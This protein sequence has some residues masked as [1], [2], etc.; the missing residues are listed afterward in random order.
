MSKIPT[1]ITFFERLIP[2]ILAGKKVITIRDQSESYYQPNTEVNLFAN[3]H[4]TYYGKLKIIAVSPLQY[5]EINAFHAQQEGMSLT[6]LKTLIKR[7]YPETNSL[8]L[9]EYQLIT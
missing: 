9:I 2:S 7:I 6:E 3:E 1:E 4:R 8:F 5:D